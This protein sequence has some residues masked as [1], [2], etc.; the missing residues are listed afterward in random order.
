MGPSA[1]VIKKGE[2]GAFL[3]TPDFTFFSPAYPLTDVPD[4]TGAGH[5]FARGFMGYI[6]GESNRD[7]RTMRMAMM[8]GTVAASYTCGSFSV[9]RLRSL[10]EQDFND[11]LRELVDLVAVGEE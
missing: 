4:P 2:H 1:A 9:D 8:C 11:R 3:F 5:S 6:A 7:G 10:T